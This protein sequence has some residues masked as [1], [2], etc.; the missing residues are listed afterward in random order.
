MKITVDFDKCASN[1]RC[2][3]ACPQ[4]FEVREDGFL[5]VLQEEPPESLRQ[6]VEQAMT[7]CPTGAISVEG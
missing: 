1:A 3:K 6:S 4:V 7:D 2:M 5:Y